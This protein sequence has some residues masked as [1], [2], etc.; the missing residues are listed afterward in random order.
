MKLVTWNVQWCRGL[1]GVVDP[2]RIVHAARAFADFD[3]LCLQEVARNFPSLAGSAG[4]DQFAA[5]QQLLPGYGA[6]FAPAVDLDDGT[7]RRSQ[8][9]NAIF[10]RRPVAQV[11]RH[12]LPWPADRAARGM[13]RSAVEVVVAD[14][15]GWVRVVT[16]HLE[17]Y[18]AAQRIAQVEALRSLHAEAA[19]HA[20]AFAQAPAALSGPFS[21]APRPASALICGDFNFRPEAPEH[22][23][24]TSP[25]PAPAPALLDAWWLQHPGRP[26]PPTLQLPDPDAPAYCSDFIFV[27]A[28][29]A[30]RVVHVAVEPHSRASDHQAVLIE[31]SDRAS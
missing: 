19:G 29:L 9:G 6:Y 3:V 24:M 20:A 31:L 5:L 23:L 16:T 22:G 26:H 2:V 25:L 12:A 27:T 17:Y 8:F 7:G 1:D 21:F 30:P 28:D 14:G 11:F 15:D 13:Q 4:E 18:S 10:S